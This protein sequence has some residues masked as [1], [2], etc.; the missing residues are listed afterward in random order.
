LSYLLDTNAVSELTKDRPSMECIDWLQQHHARCFLSVVT[1]GELVKGIELLP[2]GKKRRRLTRELRFLQEDY[3]DRILPYDEL[4][5]VE[6]GKLYASAKRNNRMLPLEDSLIEA[7][8]L[9]HELS[10]V[11]RDKA[12]FFRVQTVDPW[13]EA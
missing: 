10:V 6:W 13:S 4:S 3:R 11:T 9:T 2:E 8:A 7:I 12:H 5:A 1:V